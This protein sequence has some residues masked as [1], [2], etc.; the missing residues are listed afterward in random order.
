MTDEVGE[1]QEQSHVAGLPVIIN[2]TYLMKH[3][4]FYAV[5]EALFNEGNAASFKNSK[6]PS[7]AA[8]YAP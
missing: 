2:N 3:Q 6:Y 8:N 7:L 5:K 1:I 4:K